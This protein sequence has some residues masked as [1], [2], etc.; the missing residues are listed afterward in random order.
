METCILNQRQYYAYEH[1]RRKFKRTGGALLRLSDEALAKPNPGSD[2]RPIGFY[3][4]I[5]EKK[6][7]T[8][9]GEKSN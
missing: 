2:F 5:F 6:K 7:S 1:E 3:S 4:T 8:D 9:P